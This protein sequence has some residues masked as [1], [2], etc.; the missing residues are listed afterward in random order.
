VCFGYKYY[1][2][3]KIRKERKPGPDADRYFH[4]PC[5]KRVENPFLSI[6][7]KSPFSEIFL[8]KKVVHGWFKRKTLFKELKNIF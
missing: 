3:I 8:G 4:D 7:R 1:I 2:S 5:D 6:T